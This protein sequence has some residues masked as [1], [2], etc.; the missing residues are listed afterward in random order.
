M[1]SKDNAQPAVDDLEEARVVEFL[2][3]HPA[4]FERHPELLAS[5]RLSHPAGG[6]VS[7]IERQVAVLREQNRGLEG[8]LMELVNIARD[9]EQSSRKLHTF[10]AELLKVRSLSD[11]VAVTEDK[12]RE[13]FEADFVEVRLLPS[14]T[15]DPALRVDVPTRQAL[16]E[17][18]VEHDKPLCGR[19]KAEQ[20]EFLFGGNASEVQS[21]A[22]VGLNAAEPQGVLGLGSRH[23]QAY[24]PGMGHLFLLQLADLISSAIAVQKG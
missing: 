6:A 24:N 7:L 17:E 23:P 11:V 5:L 15:D 20:V 19:L 14:I 16:F 2:R 9:N 8:K 13:L 18:L 4:F 1:T 12:V 10:A 22:A 3:R 21:A